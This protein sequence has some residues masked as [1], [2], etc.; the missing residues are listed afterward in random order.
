[1]DKKLSPGLGN[2]TQWVIKVDIE[3]G[4][5][6]TVMFMLVLGIQWDTIVV[7]MAEGLDG[8]YGC[9]SVH[10]GVWLHPS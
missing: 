1:M 6:A 5:L 4:F 10:C 7:G 9:L 8:G 2:F 3:L